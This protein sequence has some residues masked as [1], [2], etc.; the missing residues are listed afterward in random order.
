LV[1]NISTPNLCLG[2][3]CTIQNLLYL[4]NSLM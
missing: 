1:Y 2:L 3:E 4:K